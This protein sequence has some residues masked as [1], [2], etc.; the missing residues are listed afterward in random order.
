MK[1]WYFFI[2]YNNSFDQISKITK[3]TSKNIFFCKINKNHFI[4]I[5]DR[6][7]LV[8][9]SILLEKTDTCLHFFSRKTKSL[10]L[11]EFNNFIFFITYLLKRGPTKLWKKRLILKGLGFKS[12]INSIDNSVE[13]KL[14]FSHPVLI[15]IPSNIFLKVYK[16]TLIIEGLDK[17]KVGDFTYCLRS[18]KF[19]DIYKGKGFWYKNEIKLFKEV[20]KT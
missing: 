6:Y 2:F 20:K 16:N 3:T 10:S 18:L 11:L 13:L 7:F 15:R 12:K 4:V 14:G 9:N 1:L 5:E 17:N 19:P 8:P